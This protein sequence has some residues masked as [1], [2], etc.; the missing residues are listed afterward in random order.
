MTA[1]V[2]C[3]DVALRD[4]PAFE[5]DG[6]VE[7]GFALLVAAMAA[8]GSLMLSWM[9][10]LV[11]RRKPATAAGFCVIMPLLARMALPYR[12]TPALVY[13]RIESSS[14]FMRANNETAESWK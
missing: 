14:S 8:A 7:D 12:F 5:F 9:A 13:S 6:F 4:A 3:G 1:R 11:A 2:G 10:R